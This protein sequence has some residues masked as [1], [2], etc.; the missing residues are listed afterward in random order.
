MWPKRYPRDHLRNIKAA[1]KMCVEDYFA[2]DDF[3]ETVTLARFHRM[4][5]DD[6]PKGP[7]HVGAI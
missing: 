2:N 6:G 3:K 7:K 5:P 4:L 1:S